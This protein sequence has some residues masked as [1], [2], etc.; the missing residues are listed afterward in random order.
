[1]RDDIRLHLPN[2]YLLPVSRTDLLEL[3][4]SQDSLA[5]PVKTVTV[6]LLSRRMELPSPFRESLLSIYNAGRDSSRLALKAVNELDE[7]LETGFSGSEASR[8]TSILA[9]LDAVEE[10]SDKLQTAIYDEIFALEDSVS[11]ISAVFMYK[12][13]DLLGSIA[14]NSQI[15]GN[16]LLLML[17]K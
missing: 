13:A 11:P 7:L 1:M 17:A 16:R 4:N 2:R 3:L 15:M 6:I 14:D 10:A 9:E 5:R 12:L 8:V